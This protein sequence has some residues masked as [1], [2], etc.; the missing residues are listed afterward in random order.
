MKH[1]KRAIVTGAAGFAGANLTECLIND[2]YFVYAICRPRSR[3]ND[4]LA[5]YSG[6]RLRIIELDMSAIDQLPSIIP[7]AKGTDLLFHMAWAGGRDDFEAQKCNI[8]QSIEILYAA[9]KLNV[10]RF[11]GT[12]SQAEY[13]VKENVITEDSFPE[14]FSSYG[15]A[16]LASCYLTKN[17]ASQ[18]GIEW[19]WGRIFSLIGK[20][21]PS[22]RMIPDLIKK[23]KSNDFASLSSCRQYWDYLDAGDCGRAF[24]AL[25]EKGRNGE[26]YNVAN[27]NY[28]ELRNFTSEICKLYQVDANLIHY[29][30]NPSPFVSLKPSIDKIQHDTEWKPIVPF[31]KTILLNY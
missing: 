27:G 7:E 31:E 2:N 9:T 29:G 5:S 11:I 14:P 15:A 3:H 4:R 23:L 21:E 13:G 28:R 17:L 20:Y 30:E 22:G 1:E 6:D 18:L 25:G 10:H 19:V 24:V 16:K 26:I 8:D 12:G